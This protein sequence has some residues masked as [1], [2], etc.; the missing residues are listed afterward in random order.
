MQIDISYNAQRSKADKQNDFYDVSPITFCCVGASGVG[1]TSMLAS[2]YHELDI[3]NVS[4]FY[5]DTQTQYGASTSNALA[6]AKQAMCQLIKDTEL[7]DEVK[8]SAKKGSMEE[9]THE[10]M[11][12]YVVCDDSFWVKI[13]LGKRHKVF[14]F[15]FHF[16]DMPGAWY[17]PGHTYHIEAIE[18]V[19]RSLVSFIAVDTPALME[20]DATC[21]NFNASDR[22]CQLYK[23]SNLDALRESKHIVVFVLSKREKFRDVGAMLGRLQSENLYGPMIKRL[24]ENGIP[25]YVTWIKTLGG[26]EF[27]QYAPDDENP[28]F[29]VAKYIRVGDYKPE[30]CAVPLMLGLKCGLKY[31]ADVISMQIKDKVV[32]SFLKAMRWTN[33]QLAVSAAESLAAE[34]QSDLHAGEEQEYKKL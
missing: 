13:G 10:F 18:N 5:I 17:T 2:M 31:A 24:K 8:V 1:K 3:G 16:I 25:V 29:T 20:D 32:Q 6:D 12:Q 9:K 34:L 30:N 14:T 23:G 27:F 19:K 33:K 7:Y 4:R 21:L 22:I 26:L 11:G 15:P 28:D